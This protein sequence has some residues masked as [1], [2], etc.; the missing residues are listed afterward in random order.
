MQIFGRESSWK[1]S[2]L[3]RSR[4]NRELDGTGAG[5]CPTADFGFC[6]VSPSDSVAAMVVNGKGPV[7]ISVASSDRVIY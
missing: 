2:A 5:S 6:G 1:T 7:T 4:R 3:V